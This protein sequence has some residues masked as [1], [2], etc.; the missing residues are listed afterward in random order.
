[1]ANFEKSEFNIFN[2]EKAAGRCHVIELMTCKALKGLNLMEL[3]TE[4]ELL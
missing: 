4:N 2:F 3:V 1:M